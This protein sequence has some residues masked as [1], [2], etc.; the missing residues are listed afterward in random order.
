MHSVFYGKS[1]V[2]QIVDHA[3]VHI[4]ICAFDKMPFGLNLTRKLV[5]GMNKKSSK[6]SK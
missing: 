2:T 3:W 6:Q 4:Q 1:G 5:K